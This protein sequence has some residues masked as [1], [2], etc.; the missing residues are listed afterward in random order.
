MLKP[1]KVSN[2]RSLFLT[3][4][5]ADGVRVFPDLIRSQKKTE[6]DTISQTDRFG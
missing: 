1:L 6:G 2:E 3:G 4:F 5:A